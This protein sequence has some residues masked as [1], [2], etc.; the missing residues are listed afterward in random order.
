MFFAASL[1]FNELFALDP[2]LFALRSRFW[3]AFAP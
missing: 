2:A 1:L 3:A